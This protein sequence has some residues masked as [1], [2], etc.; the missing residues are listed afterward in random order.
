MYSG[1]TLAHTG[2]TLTGIGVL[3]VTVPW[4]AL[5]AVAFVVTGAALLR[6]HHKLSRPTQ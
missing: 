2:A 4:Y 5:G 3:G 6:L 1:K